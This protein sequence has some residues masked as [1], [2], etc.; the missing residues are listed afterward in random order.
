MEGFGEIHRAD[1]GNPTSRCWWSLPRAGTM[2]AAPTPRLQRLRS[3][4]LSHES[5]WG[6]PETWPTKEEA[7][8]HVLVLN[9]GGTIGMGGTECSGG[10]APEPNKLVK[11]LKK[12]PMLHD[13][14]YAIETKLY[15]SCEFADSTLVL[16][17]SKRKKRIIYTILEYSPLLDSCNM[18]TEDWA[19]I[20]KDLETYY[21]QY[22]GFVILHGTD[23]MAYTAAALSFMCENVGK[24]IV[25]TGSQVPIYELRN[26]GRSNL[27]GALLIAGQFVIPEVCLYFH[28]KL[29]R[30]NRV[31]KVDAGSFDAFS[32]PNLPPLANAEVDIKIDWG[33]I[34]RA[35]TTKK[36]EVHT[37]MNRNVGLLRIFPGITAATV[38]AFLQPPMEGI[39][40]ETY[41]SGNAP[42]NRA[43]LLEELRLAT[44]RNV[45][46]LNCTQC[47]RG[48]VASTYATGQDLAHVGVIS[49]GD[50]MPEASLAKLSYVLGKKQL[51][52]KEKKKMLAD[53]LRGEMSST[54]T[55]AQSSLRNSHFIKVITKFISL[56]CK[57]ELGA[58]IPSLACAAAKTGD[59]DALKAIEEVGGNLSCEDY[60]GRT[61][62]HVASSEG[63]VQ[64]VEY[65]LKTGASVYAKDRY[66]ATPLM[67]AIEFRHMKVIQLLRETGAHLSSEELKNAGTKLCLL[68]ANGDVDGLMAWHIAGVDMKQNDYNSRT[69]LQVVLQNERDTCH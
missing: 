3:S 53:N 59:M 29:Y 42:N 31:T 6:S 55:G 21:E 39:V 67:N 5:L 52:W 51:N 54:L 65:L 28:H 58:L 60:D 30:G 50:M 62:L 47:L 69:P 38:K 46:I 37:N 25:L 43:D 24:T 19:K 14:E 16:P 12:M 36:F 63:H 56:N 44:E 68:A 32:S 1:C 10:L 7:R 17:L 34:W 9:T 48:S 40:L 26:D 20:A 11:T 18:T 45:V 13:E 2:A 22:D 57:E 49:G 61:P 33:I 4:S 8:A 41:G 35:N 15:D 66:G 27:L 64:L 23:T